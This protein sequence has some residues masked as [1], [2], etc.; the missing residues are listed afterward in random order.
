MK[1]KIG[2]CFYEVKFIEN[3]QDEKGKKL[4][5]FY[6][7]KKGEILIEKNLHPQ[8]RF[9]TFLHEIIHAILEETTIVHFIKKSK[10]EDFVEILAVWLAMFIID[11]DIY[12]ILKELDFL[13][14]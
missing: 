5:G 8:D 11:N 1:V 14:K 7:P 12:D 2:N 6:N 9:S 3:L 13:E 10:I 4:D